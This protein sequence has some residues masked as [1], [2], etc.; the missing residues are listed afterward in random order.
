MARDFPAAAAARRLAPAT[1]RLPSPDPGR[2]G[3]RAPHGQQPRSSGVVTTMPASLPV[4]DH[5][6]VPA[7]AVRE[8]RA[9]AQPGRT[10]A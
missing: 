10:G 5:G 9:D 2:R 4:A 1:E 7:A 3:E 6:V 8:H